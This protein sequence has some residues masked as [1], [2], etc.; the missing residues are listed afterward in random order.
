MKTLNLKSMTLI[1]MILNISIASHLQAS[2]YMRSKTVSIMDN[3]FGIVRSTCQIPANWQLQSNIYT[4]PYTGNI[5]QFQC[6]FMGQKASISVMKSVI[7][8]DFNS[9][10]TQMLKS[11]LGR[12]YYQCNFSQVKVNKEIIRTNEI[13]NASQSLGGKARGYEQSFTLK[14]NGGTLEGKVMGYTISTNNGTIMG[15]S[16][17]YAHTGAMNKAMNAWRM[18]TKTMKANPQFLQRQQMVHQKRMG[19]IYADGVR[20]SREHFQKTQRKMRELGNSY[21]QNNSDYNQ[22]L[23][24]WGSTDNGNTY[25]TSEKYS[26][27]YGGTTT[28][29][30]PYTGQQQKADGYYDY[31]WVN[32]SGQV[33]GTNDPNYDPRKIYGWSWK[34]APKG[35]S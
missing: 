6:V 35:G 17:L 2:N 7:S 34:K 28:I 26:D 23:K 33:Y 10:W 30:N 8:Q 24:D 9:S 18:V 5:E 13:R 15:G 11:S 19:Q 4:N 20:N 25:S 21:S 1:M 27:Y 12:D 16:I 32:D 22:S 14:V 29:E 31:Y 3:G